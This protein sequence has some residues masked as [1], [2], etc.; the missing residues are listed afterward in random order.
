MHYFYHYKLHATNHQKAITVEVWIKRNT[1]NQFSLV[2][3]L[4]FLN[5][6]SGYIGFIFQNVVTEEEEKVFS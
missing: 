4:Y 1:Q 6:I 3:L 2:S 5:Y